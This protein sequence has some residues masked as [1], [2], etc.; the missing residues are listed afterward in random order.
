MMRKA[1]GFSI[2]R[3]VILMSRFILS[4]A[5]ICFVGI[6]STNASAQSFDKGKDIL[7]QAESFYKG[8]CGQALKGAIKSGAADAKTAKKACAA[9]RGC[10]K[11]CRTAK[12]NA[13]K[14]CKGLKGKDKRKC[15]KAARKGKRNC[16]KDCR[17]TAKTKECRKARFALIKALGQS[18]K[19][20]AKNPQCKAFAKKAAAAIKRAG[21]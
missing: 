8:S 7:D 13:K 21:E 20:L 10:K 11:T 1:A 17:K 5:A 2:R 6:L 15:K 19:T 4:I 3:G 9:F 12:R 16:V 14:S 18:A